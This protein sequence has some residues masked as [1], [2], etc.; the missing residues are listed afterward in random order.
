MPPKVC[1][2]EWF[3]EELDKRTLPIWDPIIRRYSKYKKIKSLKAF[4]QEESSSIEAKSDQIRNVFY[5]CEHF[6]RIE[7]KFEALSAILSSLQAFKSQMEIY[8]TFSRSEYSNIEKITFENQ[9]QDL[10]ALQYNCALNFVDRFNIS[11][12]PTTKMK[13]KIFLEHQQKI[14]KIRIGLKKVK[15]ALNK[16]RDSFLQILKKENIESKQVNSKLN[17][18]IV[19]RLSFEDQEDRGIL[20]FTKKISRIYGSNSSGYKI[21]KKLYQKI[22]IP[23]GTNE[24]RLSAKQYESLVDKSKLIQTLGNMGFKGKLKKLFWGESGK[25]NLD[26]IFYPIITKSDLDKHGLDVLELEKLFDASNGFKIQ[27]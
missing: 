15:V 2:E 6:G 22:M 12:E 5:A 21:L 8:F 14:H 7:L 4:V 20:I 24:I 19:F 23:E 27:T 1:L 3:I 10:F 13:Q 11:L 9:I 17:D 26:L 16:L 25:K 18:E